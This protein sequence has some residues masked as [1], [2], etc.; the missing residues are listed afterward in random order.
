MGI[1]FSLLN[2]ENNNQMGAALRPIIGENCSL[3]K[4]KNSESKLCSITKIAKEKK[5]KYT[6]DVLFSAFQ[7]RKCHFL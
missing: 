7:L 2:H 5:V 4:N 6:K 3:H 1:L